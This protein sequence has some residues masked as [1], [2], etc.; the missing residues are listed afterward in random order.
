MMN[1]KRKELIVMNWLESKESLVEQLLKLKEQI[2][3]EELELLWYEITQR[4]SYDTEEN[5]ILAK[6]L[7]LLSDDI[8]LYTE[9]E[10]DSLIETVK[11][12]NC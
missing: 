5:Y 4:V 10:I 12:I 7:Y 11:N 2:K 8:E 9:K 6:A 1:N 3:L